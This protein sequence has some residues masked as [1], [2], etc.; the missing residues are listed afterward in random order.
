[1]NITAPDIITP[2]PHEKTIDLRVERLR[3]AIVRADTIHASLTPQLLSA[4][5]AVT[6]L[7][8]NR[9]FV[10]A[11]T[12]ALI[13]QIV[14]STPRDL[15]DDALATSVRPLTLLIEQANIATARMRQI[16]GAHQ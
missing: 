8:E 11:H 3:D 15:Q 9:V 6:L 16:I 4:T 13:E 12:Q 1:M 7:V 2:G 10:A 14:A 5:R